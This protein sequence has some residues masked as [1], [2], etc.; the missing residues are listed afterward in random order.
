MGEVVFGGLDFGVLVGEVGEFGFE[1]GN[2]LL[3][4]LDLVYF[5]MD[6]RV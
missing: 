3:E 4:F 2:S 6:V 5:L 1:G